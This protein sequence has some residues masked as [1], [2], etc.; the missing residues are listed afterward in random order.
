MAEE[1]GFPD[2]RD[3]AVRS[4]FE[5]ER[6]ASKAYSILYGLVAVTSV[7]LDRCREHAGGKHL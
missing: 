2:A 7:Y 6:F 1:L 4:S 5:T 3:E